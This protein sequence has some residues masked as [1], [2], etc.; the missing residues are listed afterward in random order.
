M[1]SSQACKEEIWLKGFLGEFGRM[2]DKVKVLQDSQIVFQLD[3]N[4]TYHSKMKNISIK[5]HFLLQALDEGGVT[6][7][8][9]HTKV[10]S[11]D[12]FN[13]PILLGKIEWC[14]ACLGLNKR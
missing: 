4:P 11:A 13:K 12:M 7:E 5:Y 6:L 9:L 10:T 14:L 3:R 2:Q 1:A 8:N